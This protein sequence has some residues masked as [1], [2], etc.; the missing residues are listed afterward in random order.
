MGLITSQLYLAVQS[1]NFSKR[2]IDLTIF[3][4]DVIYP[5]RFIIY[6]KLRNNMTKQEGVWILL[7]ENPNDIM[8]LGLPVVGDEIRIDYP[9]NSIP[10]NGTAH[11]T[12]SLNQNTRKSF[13][14]PEYGATL[15]YSSQFGS[16]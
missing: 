7:E 14:C 9:D 12:G 3:A 4:I 8:I 16:D 11:R 5:C 2:K 10:V 6:K 13:A 1:K 15:I